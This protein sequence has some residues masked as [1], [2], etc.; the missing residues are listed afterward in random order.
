MLSTIS[1]GGGTIDTR[2]YDNGGRLT[3]ETLGNGQTVT[4]SYATNEHLVASI[5]NANVGTYSYTWDAN[6]RQLRPPTDQG[7]ARPKA[8]ERTRSITGV[9][10]GYGFTVPT[11]GYDDEDRLVGWNRNDSALSHAWSLTAAGNWSTLTTNGTPQS[12]THGNA[13]E[14]TAIGANSLTYDAKGNLTQD[15]QGRTYAWDMDNLLS[16]TT[17]SMVAV[18]YAYDALGRRV[19]RT[20]GSTTVSVSNGPIV[21]SEYASGGAAN[22]PLRKFLNGSYVDEPVLLIDRTALGATGAGTDERLY[23]HRNQQYSITALTNNSGTVVER[24]AYTAYGQPT[25][26]NAAASST[27]TT[28]DYGN[29]YLFTARSYEPDTGLHYFRARY[30]QSR[31]GRFISRDPTAYNSDGPSAYAMLKSSPVDRKD[32]SGL[33]SLHRPEGEEVKILPAT[34][35]DIAHVEKLLAE[36]GNWIDDVKDCP[37][38][39]MRDKH[40]TPILRGGVGNIEVSLSHGE[41]RT[42]LF[43]AICRNDCDPFSGGLAQRGV[44]TKICIRAGTA[45]PLAILK[46]EAVHAHQFCRQPDIDTTCGNCTTFER[47]AYKVMCKEYFDP[48][49][50]AAE[51]L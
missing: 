30:L 12:R 29:P 7:G 1:Y 33:E 5:A 45:N 4:R 28:S 3:S 17:E 16:S 19:S 2:T 41:S 9:M 32:P 15:D 48:K 10:S 47:D 43:L 22:S 26:L 21:V 42:C 25:I 13:H 51:Y 46:H 31:L 20:A 39:E 35:D 23:Y 38:T 40:L 8:A 50:E 34:E 11:G 6:H 24:Y 36:H 18:S 49:K 37:C 27:R 44:F 14:L